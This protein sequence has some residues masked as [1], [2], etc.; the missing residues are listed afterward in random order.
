ML[1]SI[2]IY[3][4]LKRKLQPCRLYYSQGFLKIKVLRRNISHIQRVLWFF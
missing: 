2:F 3:T 4:N 1:I